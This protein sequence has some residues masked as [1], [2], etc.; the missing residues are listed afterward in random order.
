M[1]DL[2]LT[3]ELVGPSRFRVSLIPIE[4]AMLFPHEADWRECAGNAAL[5]EFIGQCQDG[6][7]SLSKD[8]SALL[9]DLL[10]KMR[11]AKPRE[12]ILQRSH[13][14][15]R[16]G[17]VAS[18]ILY[19]ALTGPDERPSLNAIKSILQ[20]RLKHYEES[21]PSL[22]LS[23]MDNTVWKNFK[24]VSHLHLAY[25][26][27]W[28]AHGAKTYPFPCRYDDLPVFLKTAESIRIEGEQTLLRQK[29]GTVLD[30]RQTWKAP[31][32]CLREAQSLWP[33]DR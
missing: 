21:F 33:L 8:Q 19:Q 10:A 9:L 15:L 14:H 22:S 31:S 25:A 20:E 2:E 18:A 16:H 27:V 13:R 26:L 6:G 7:A 23:T 12:A 30:P 1:P 17:A 5:C 4:I 28:A 11:T 3:P 24:A 29:A 32:N